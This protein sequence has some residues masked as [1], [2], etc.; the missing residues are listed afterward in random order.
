MKVLGKILNTR[1]IFSIIKIIFS[2][3]CEIL[4]ILAVHYFVQTMPAVL[5]VVPFVAFDI[6]LALFSIIY[7]RYKSSAAARRR[8]KLV[9]HST[10]PLR[11]PGHAV[12]PCSIVAQQIPLNYC[13][14]SVNPSMHTNGT[15]PPSHCRFLLFSFPICLF[16]D[17]MVCLV[18]CG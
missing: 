5:L 10:V 7:Y 15:S 2:G 1:K 12:V 17:I 4:M 14:Q 9:H 16:S 13:Y 3:L 8:A 11:I 6:V 18:I